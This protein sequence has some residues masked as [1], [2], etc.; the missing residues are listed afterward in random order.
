VRQVSR[1]SPMAQRCSGAPR[2]V[3]AASVPRH[4]QGP[5]RS[6]SWA[7]S[8]T[9]RATNDD[10]M[11]NSRPRPI[12]PY[13]K[14]SRSASTLASASTP[15]S[16]RQSLDLVGGCRLLA[17]V[18]RAPPGGRSPTALGAR[19]DPIAADPGQVHRHFGRLFV[20]VG[21][22]ARAPRRRGNPQAASL[23][24][25]RHLHSSTK[26]LVWRRPRAE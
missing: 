2:S 20:R 25:V 15:P 26:R 16:R 7:G 5:G 1:P 10:S 13:V 4:L 23:D 24:I 9:A 3:E 8:P 21:T 12:R 17:V 22:P 18:A 19:P 6:R 11:T 14:A